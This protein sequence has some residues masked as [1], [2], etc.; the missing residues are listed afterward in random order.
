MK[1]IFTLLLLIG[2]FF[3]GC[4]KYEDGPFFSFKSAEKRLCQNWTASK[5]LYKGS[6]KIQFIVIQI[7][8]SIFAY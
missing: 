8:I 1:K 7:T 6:S 4:T 2:L 5:H 3:A